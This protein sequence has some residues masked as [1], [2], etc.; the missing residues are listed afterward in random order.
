MTLENKNLHRDGNG[1]NTG[2][3]FVVST[4]IALDTVSPVGHSCIGCRCRPPA[5]GDFIFQEPN[6]RE[7]TLKNEDF[8][9]FSKGFE[10]TY[11]SNSEV[12]I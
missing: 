6:R 2:D 7:T 1:S 12:Y 9:L 4:S 10:E 5:L 8:I 3:R 11:T